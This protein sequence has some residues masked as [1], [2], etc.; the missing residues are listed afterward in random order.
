MNKTAD[1]RDQLQRRANELSEV[2]RVAKELLGHKSNENDEL[3]K[4]VKELEA[5]Y[6]S[7]HAKFFPVSS[8]PIETD[9]ACLKQD[10]Q[11]LRAALVECKNT[12]NRLLRFA[13]TREAMDIAKTLST[14]NQL[15]GEQG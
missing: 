15:L 6:G 10:K 12:L 11:S 4:R 5:A 8:R 14:L 7:L 13:T 2:N 3:Q 9:I 1:E